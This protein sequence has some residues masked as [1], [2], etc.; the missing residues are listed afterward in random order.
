VKC[1]PEENEPLTKKKNERS[2]EIKRCREFCS[3]RN[4]T[5]VEIQTNKAKSHRRTKIREKKNFN[6]KMDPLRGFKREREGRS[7]M[8]CKRR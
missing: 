8:E 1:R 2:E 7:P 6:G 3:G 4:R 5:A